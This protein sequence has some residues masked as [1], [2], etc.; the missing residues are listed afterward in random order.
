M[1]NFDIDIINL[2]NLVINNRGMLSIL[3]TTIL[4]VTVV[5]ISGIF[6]YALGA[7]VVLKVTLA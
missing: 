2:Y 6:L 4:V 5:V 1:Y 7:R 3:N